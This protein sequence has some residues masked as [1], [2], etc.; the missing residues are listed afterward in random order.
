LWRGEI[1]AL[2]KK[3]FKNPFFVLL[4]QNESL[5]FSAHIKGKW[6]TP[7]TDVLLLIAI[8]L[9]KLTK[10]IWFSVHLKCNNQHSLAATSMQ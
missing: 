9:T 7:R 4:L 10:G 1:I 6:E 5:P 2:D 8:Y 3:S